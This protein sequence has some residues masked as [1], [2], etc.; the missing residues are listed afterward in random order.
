[1]SFLSSALVS[2]GQKGK[3]VTSRGSPYLYLHL[4]FLLV[5]ALG[6]D[7]ILYAVV[8]EEVTGFGQMVVWVVLKGG[9]P[10][11]PDY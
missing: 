3:R 10:D 4:V 1:M 2:S 5:P 11:C 6:A 7:C 9:R 8:R